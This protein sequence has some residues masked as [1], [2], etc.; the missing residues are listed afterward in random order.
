[1][2]K[3]FI[4][5]SGKFSNGIANILKYWI[6]QVFM[7]TDEPFVSSQDIDKGKTWIHELSNELANSQFGI[8]CVTASNFESPWLHFEAGAILKQLGVSNVCPFLYKVENSELTGPLSQFQTTVFE[9]EDVFGLIQSINNSCMEEKVPFNKLKNQFEKWWPELEGKIQQLEQSSPD[10]IRKKGSINNEN[11]I[12]H[13]LDTQK[14]SL[15]EITAKIDK[16]GLDYPNLLNMF[17]D[18][19]GVTYR[20]S[21]FGTRINH[22]SYEKKA[23]ARKTI[24]VLQKELVSDKEMKFC[25]L[26]DSGTTTYDLFCEIS[27]R[28]K[29]IRNDKKSKERNTILDIWMNRIFIIT[30]NL[31]GIQYLIKNCRIG[32]DEYSDLAIKCLLLPGKPLPVYAA[33]AGLE[34]IEFLNK[35]KIKERIEKELGIKKNEQYKIISIMSGN[36]IVRH[37]DISSGKELFCPVARGGEIGG[38]YDIK[39]AFADLSDKIYLISPLTKFSFATCECLNKINGYN[40]NAEERPEDARAFPDKV[41]YREI[42]LTS[43]EL[44]E[45]CNFVL[46]D[47]KYPDIF[48]NFARDLRREI[49]K[50]YGESKINNAAYNIEEVIFSGR[51][52]PKYKDLEIEIEIPHENLRNAYLSYIKED[53]DLFIW[54]YYWIA[55]SEDECHEAPKYR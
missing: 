43:E 52:N 22:F 37:H 16:I 48:R 18:E 6:P 55:R 49:R 7:Q 39:K 5:W 54:S 11:K 8:L 50:S 25:L 4:G 21:I 30:N 12:L 38:H 14:K 10:Y 33:V 41:K 17:M 9:K 42:E 36:Y 23:L 28:I 1:M 53:D 27:D 35:N 2:R 40:I 19:T 20:G 32:P 29:K 26:I 47:R 34:T 15:K 13:L 24:D 31:P 46:T 44:I 3:I 51:D 45:K